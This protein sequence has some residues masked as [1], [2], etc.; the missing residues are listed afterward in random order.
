MVNLKLIFDSGDMEIEG[1]IIRKW[2]DE[3]QRVH[4]AIFFEENDRIGKFIY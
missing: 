2:D 1:K 3:F 4:L